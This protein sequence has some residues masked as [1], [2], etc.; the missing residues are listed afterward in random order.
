M[1]SPI[2][3]P[4]T[5]LQAQLC[6]CVWLSLTVLESRGFSKDNVVLVNLL[7]RIREF[8]LSHCISFITPVRALDRGFEPRAGEEA[9]PQGQ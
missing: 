4:G 8:R 5:L 9:K 3:Q 2:L 1:S 7:T 6:P